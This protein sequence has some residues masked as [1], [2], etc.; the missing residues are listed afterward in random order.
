[1]PVSDHT[2]QVGPQWMALSQKRTRP[3]ITVPGAAAGKK[4][5]KAR[6]NQEKTIFTGSG[7]GKSKKVRG[8]EAHLTDFWRSYLGLASQGL[9]LRLLNVCTLSLGSFAAMAFHCTETA[10]THSK[11]LYESWTNIIVKSSGGRSVR[12]CHRNQTVRDDVGHVA[13]SSH[14]FSSGRQAGSNFSE[15]EIGVRD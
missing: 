4:I 7:A 15:W 12:L 3:K 11:D 13:R 5:E 9:L 8:F 2:N 14:H 10:C 1:M 6:K